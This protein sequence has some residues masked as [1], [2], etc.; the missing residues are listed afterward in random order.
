MPCATASQGFRPSAPGTAAT[1]GAS[2]SFAP[3]PA[4]GSSAYSAALLGSEGG[5]LAGRLADVV[6]VGYRTTDYLLLV[7]GEGGAALPDEARSGS[8]DAGRSQVVDAVRADVA[9]QGGV[10]CTPPEGLVEATVSAGEHLT[11]RGRAVD[12]RPATWPAGSRPKATGHGVNASTTS[13]RCS[14]RAVAAPRW[15]RNCGFPVCRW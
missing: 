6:D 13:P 14:S 1:R 7:P 4:A 12:L 15:H 11:V 10:P 5:R 8:V 3:H 9:A 2:R